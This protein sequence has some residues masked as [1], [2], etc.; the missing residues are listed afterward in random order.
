MPDQRYDL[1]EAERILGRAADAA[2]VPVVVEAREA[3]ARE[4][5]EHL[6]QLDGKSGIAVTDASSSCLQV[7]IGDVSR[8][9]GQ[10]GGRIYIATEGRQATDHEGRT[11]PLEF[12]PADKL[13]RGPAYQERDP[14]TGETKTKHRDALVTVVTAVVRALEVR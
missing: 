3:A 14:A 2:D 9:V 7:R 1:R 6:R 5:L 10:R 11:V 8:F 13:L 12:D 4:L